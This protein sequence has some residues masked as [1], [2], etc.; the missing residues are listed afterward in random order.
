MVS[1][2]TNEKMNIINDMIIII[3]DIAIINSGRLFFK[4][5]PDFKCFFR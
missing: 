3:N 5:S 1:L 4:I 2:F